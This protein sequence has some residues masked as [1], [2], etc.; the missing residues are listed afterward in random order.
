LRTEDK[1][2]DTRE[3]QQDQGRES[4]LEK[5]DDE[6]LPD[7]VEREQQ[8]D[9]ELVQR[10]AVIAAM[11]LIFEGQQIVVNDLLLPRRERLALEALKAAVEGRDQE[12]AQFVY[13]SDRRD[14]LEQALAIL[15]PSVALLEGEPFF[16]QL[17]H[18]VGDLRERLT[19]LE[20]AQDELME[21]P[22]QAL[23]KANPDE[24]DEADEVEVDDDVPKPS[25]LFGPEG[26][27]I[28]KPPSALAEVEPTFDVVL[29]VA[30]GEKTIEIMR[31]IRD[32]TGAG[33][34][35]AKELAEQTASRVVMRT[36]DRAAAAAFKQRLEAIGG[37]VAVIATGEPLPETPPVI[38]PAV[39]DKELG[40]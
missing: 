30:P 12:I 25:T 18:R 13:A 20:D 11:Q 8:P 38:E 32:A 6:V 5:Q 39:D 40:G 34:F 28:A 17:V 31:E 23:A 10:A 26:P 14:L 21:R 1:E 36:P 15:Q 19:S 29:I 7:L 16:D 37:V 24:A 2:I 9:I 22:Q 33:L 4:E 35:D 3:L 27:I